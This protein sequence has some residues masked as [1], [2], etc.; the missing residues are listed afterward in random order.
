MFRSSLNTYETRRYVC[1]PDWFDHLLCLFPLP[2][3]VF[4]VFRLQGI[5]RVLL[6]LNFDDLL[7][8]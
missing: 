8:Y 6:D 2:I 1:L 5:I 4:A 3:L 7:G